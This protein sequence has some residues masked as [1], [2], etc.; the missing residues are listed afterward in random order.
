MCS[1]WRFKALVQNHIQF[2]SGKNILYAL[3][4]INVLMYTFKHK[5]MHIEEFV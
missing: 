4:E 1:S 2:I 3:Y 5:M